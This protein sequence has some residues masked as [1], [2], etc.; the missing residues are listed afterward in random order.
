MNRVEPIYAITMRIQ[1]LLDDKISSNHRQEVLDEINQLLIQRGTYMEE[2]SEPYT[3][4]ELNLGKQ[5]V[6]LNKS[7]QEKMDKLFKTL[8]IEM[9]QLKQQKNSNR[10]Y[11]NPYENVQTVD[12][13][14]M[15]KKK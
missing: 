5:I 11:I 8:K 9:K 12:G 2:I 13:M 10:K 1:E 3:S 7:I 14:F 4:E 6:T 15:D